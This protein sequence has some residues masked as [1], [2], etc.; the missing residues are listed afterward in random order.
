MSKGDIWQYSLMRP[1][2]IG[3]EDCV[4]FLLVKGVSVNLQTKTEPTPLLLALENGHE[5]IV[6]HIEKNTSRAL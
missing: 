3:Y 1:R 2:N 4:R 5:H 6:N